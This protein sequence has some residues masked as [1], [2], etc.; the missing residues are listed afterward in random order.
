MNSSLQ[1]GSLR[2]DIV[3]S[4]AWTLS[5]TAIPWLGSATSIG[6]DRE[7]MCKNIKLPKL[8]IPAAGSETSISP[9]CSILTLEAQ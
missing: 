3:K 1:Y 5:A 4:S 2:H 7:I 8:R 9:R 6:P